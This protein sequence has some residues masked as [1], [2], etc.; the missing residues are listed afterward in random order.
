VL[1]DL[2]AEQR[3]EAVSS[4][5]YEASERLRDPVHG[6]LGVINDLQ[7]KVAELETQLAST[8]AALANMSL[9]YANLLTLITGCHEASDPNFYSTS[10]QEGQDTDRSRST[11]VVDDV[12]PLQLWDQLWT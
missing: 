6:S 11:T 1:Q 10:A 8:D 12:E 3:G 9:Q 2:P 5:V 4:L 7:K